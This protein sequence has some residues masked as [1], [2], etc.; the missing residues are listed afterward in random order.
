MGLVPPDSAQHGLSCRV[1]PKAPAPKLAPSRQIPSKRLLIG[2]PS[3]R[4]GAITKGQALSLLGVRHGIKVR[5]WTVALLF[6]SFLPPPRF[7]QHSRYVVKRTLSFASLSLSLSLES[8]HAH[9]TPFVAFV[10]FVLPLAFVPFIVLYACRTHF[11]ASLYSFVYL[12]LVM[13]IDL[14]VFFFVCVA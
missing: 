6:S 3:Q 10:E 14:T 2:R 9:S 5:V 12:A 7:Q 11:P 8:F 13:W 4:A 1:V